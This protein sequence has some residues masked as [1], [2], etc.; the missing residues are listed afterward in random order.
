MADHLLL[1]T[2]LDLNVNRQGTNPRHNLHIVYW[3][4]FRKELTKETILYGP[5]HNTPLLTVVGIGDG[6]RDGGNVLC[7]RDKTI[8]SMLLPHLNGLNLCE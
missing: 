5:Y 4:T 6:D 2:T 3:D 1:H 7:A 8:V